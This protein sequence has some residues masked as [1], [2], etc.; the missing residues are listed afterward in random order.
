MI[1]AAYDKAAFP[2]PYTIL[3]QRLK[4]F[5]L[6]HY[7]LLRRLKS[8]FV[9]DKQ[10]ESSVGDLI[11]GV[12]VCSRNY[13]GASEII[14]D[15]DK[16]EVEAQRVGELNSKS[17]VAENQNEAIA[18][19]ILFNKYVVDGSAMP[20]YFLDNEGDYDRKLNQHWSQSV[21]L[22]LISNCG[23]TRDEALNCPLS[24]AFF[25]HL[26]FMETEGSIKLMS[27][28]ELEEV[29]LLENMEGS[30]V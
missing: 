8:P 10:E 11:V 9:S 7:I 27:E 5:S 21:L 19:I 6:G 4:P 30:N 1:H 26:A 14:C 2:E 20:G 29:R 24:Q 15:F 25:D 22:S 12:I 23:Y 16:M 18:R 28:E 3:G 17:G 13:S